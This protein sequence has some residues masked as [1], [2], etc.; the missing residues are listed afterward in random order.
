MR[1]NKDSVTPI[2]ITLGTRIRNNREMSNPA[3]KLRIDRPYSDI[4]VVNSLYA[5]IILVL[6]Q[7]AL[8]QN[9]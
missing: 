1:K 8:P 9:F 7:S 2:E 6:Q 4:N 3:L 5:R